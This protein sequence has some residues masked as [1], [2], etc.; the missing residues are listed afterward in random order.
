MARR[1]VSLVML[2]LGAALGVAAFTMPGA[3]ARPDAVREG[4]TFRVALHNV[5]S[6]DPAMAY[7]PTS[8]LLLEATCANLI[9]YPDRPVPDGLLPR[10]EVALRMRISKDG[11]TY[12]F[13]LRRGFRFSNGARLDADSFKRQITRILVLKSDGL[14]YV[15]DI[16]GAGDVL[17]GRS[18]SPAGV[19]ARGSSLV[20]RLTRPIPDFRARLAMPFFCA[21]PPGLPA[22]PE[23]VE[24][25]ASAGPYY[26]AEYVPGRRA[27]LLRNRH[28]GG[29]RR[30]HVDR[31]EVDL[32]HGPGEIAG[33][34]ERGRADWGFL[35]PNALGERLRG[36]VRKYRLNRSRLFT[37]PKPQLLYFLLNTERPLFKNNPR[38]RQAINFAVDRSALAAQHGFRS[39]QPTDQYLP[40]GFPGFRNAAIYPMSPNVRRARALARGRLRGGRAVLY[41]LGE[42]PASSSPRW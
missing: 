32:T 31:F 10:P 38:L 4:G 40:I 2:A 9:N 35:P 23:G 19:I 21:V 1:G 11:R 5:D 26:V 39:V 37:R 27:V 8:W 34:I 20:I 3:N 15:R 6:L 16:V 7:L 24:E 18:S 22:D 41:T 42:P 12:R 36:L 13:T 30:H 14:Q 33:E 17:A 29:K 25:F 28:Y